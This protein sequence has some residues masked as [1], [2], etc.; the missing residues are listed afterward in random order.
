MRVVVTGADGYLGRPLT[1]ELRRAG[2]EVTLLDA[3]LYRAAVLDE[4][5]ADTRGGDTRDLDAGFFAGHDAVVHLAELSNDPL[6]ELD[7]GLTIDINHKGSVRLADLA[8]EAGVDRFL[9]FS[10]CSVYGATGSDIVDETGPTKPLTAYARCKV[11]VEQDLLGHDR[12]DL[13][14]IL[15]RNATVYGPSPALRLDLAIN[16]FVYDAVLGGR[17]NM[18]SAGTS[19]R[20]FVHCEDIAR[21]GRTLLEAP[22]DVVSRQ[23]INIGS[24]EATVTVREAADIVAE[25]TGVEVHIE[26][27]SLDLRDY[28]VSFEKLGRLVPELS[29]RPI[30]EGI[31]ELVTFLQD[32]VEEFRSRPK[33]DFF[34]LA[35]LKRQ[36]EAHE[37]DAT[38]RRTAQA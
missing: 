8:A 12:G 32:N 17:V 28:R 4:G 15:M 35:L 36:L 10:S 20:P 16:E 6:G 26:S 11:A 31:G 38:L 30:H 2:H 7:E 9:Y 37:L 21:A 19:W 29:M 3:G 13:H 14:P 23:I 25:H 34:R 33:D 5:S 18:R 27:D 22:L 1:A 24:D